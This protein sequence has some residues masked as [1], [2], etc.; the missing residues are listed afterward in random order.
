MCRACAPLQGK[1]SCHTGYRKSAG[2]N[3]PVGFLAEEGIMPPVN[4]NSGVQAD[5]QSV[6]SF[7][8]KVR[9]SLAAAR[10]TAC[11][12]AAAFPAGGP[13]AR[14]RPLDALI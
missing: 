4:T 1:N 10:C 6:A 9:I 14:K 3:V 13:A 5:A 2:W 12:A 8:G 11:P 7:F